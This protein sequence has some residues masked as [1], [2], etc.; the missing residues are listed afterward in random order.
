MKAI[1]LLL[2]LSL[3]QA[4]VQE[5]KR[6]PKQVR[7]FR[8][9]HACPSTKLTAGSCPGW[10]VDHIIPLCW[11][12]ADEPKNMMWQDQQSS[13][14]KDKFEREACAMKKKTEGGPK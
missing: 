1:L 6:D 10:V 7:A 2:A 14:I 11:G 8:K 13:Y 3:A 5:A 12:G 9:A 4:D